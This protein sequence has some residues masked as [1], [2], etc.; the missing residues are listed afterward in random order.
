MH[1]RPSAKKLNCI[2]QLNSY[3]LEKYKKYGQSCSIIFLTVLVELQP[4]I[5]KFCML[6]A[7]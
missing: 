1:S 7:S 3:L 4:S 2:Q 6:S 5:D